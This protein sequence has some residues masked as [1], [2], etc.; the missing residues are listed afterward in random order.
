MTFDEFKERV[1]D[2]IQ[3]GA[4]KLSKELSE[5]DLAIQYAICMEMQAR[6][7]REMEIDSERIYHLIGKYCGDEVLE[8]VFAES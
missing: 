1:Q 4:L 3:S 5:L 6:G 2:G 8:R 7:V